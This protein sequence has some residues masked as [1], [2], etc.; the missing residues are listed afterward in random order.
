MIA[1]W[2]RTVG[3]WL[4]L[5]RP[6]LVVPRAQRTKA[7]AIHAAVSLLGAPAAAAQALFARRCGAP[8]RDVLFA[9]RDHLGDFLMSV[10]ALLLFRERMPEARTTVVLQDRYRAIAAGLPGWKKVVD[11]TIE[12]PGEGSSFVASFRW[13]RAHFRSR[14]YDTVVFHRLTR[15]D[16]PAV[17]AAFLRGVPT[18][19]G[20]ADKGLQ[21]LLT[22]C[23]FPAGRERVAFYHLNLVAAWLGIEPFRTAD[24]LKW[25][26]APRESGAGEKILLFPFAQHSKTWSEAAWREVFAHLIGRGFPVAVVGSE[27]QRAAAA[28][29]TEGF[30][31]ENLC[32]TTDLPGLFALVRAARG[33]IGLDTGTRHV[34]TAFGV[35]CVVL[36]HG[37]E[38]RDLMGAYAP[39][40]RYLVT[41]VPCAPCG[42]E[43]CPLVHLHCIRLTPAAAV[44]AAFDELVP[45]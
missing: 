16:F 1:P 45:A 6:R 22:H 3:G 37:R 40:E 4:R 30:P 5:M 20:G 36:G 44:I 12:A 11:E 18:R 15:P 33:L 26:V 9:S 21:A 41:P 24:Y 28:A 27:G 39:T 43:P 2:F 7:R 31:I 34:A 38:H 10:P 13:W 23:Y 25:P 14:S 32:G 8:P 19:V 35:P 29:L 42:A 17:L